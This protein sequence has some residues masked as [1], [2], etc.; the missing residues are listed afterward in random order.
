MSAQAT[1]AVGTDRHDSCHDG[2]LR[3]SY[4]DFKHS[5]DACLASDSRACYNSYRRSIEQRFD[6]GDEVARLEESMSAVAWGLDQR[7]PAQPEDRSLAVGRRVAPGR[8]DS[9]RATPPAPVTAAVPRLKEPGFFGSAPDGAR[10]S[11]APRPKE[12][13]FVAALDGAEYSAVP[14]LREAAVL[15]SSRLARRSR[16]ALV[17]TALV[18]AGAM[19]WSSLGYADAAE[20]ARV[21]VVPAGGSLSEVAAAELPDVPLGEAIV[22]IQLANRMNGAQV[23]AGQELMIPPAP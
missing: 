5:F 1:A 23:H 17:V 9:I 7:V 19:S 22:A 18:F 15:G 21:V 3:W 11:A 4:T 12:A 20:P 13:T 16:V 8:P 6:G 2:S 10:Y 14:R